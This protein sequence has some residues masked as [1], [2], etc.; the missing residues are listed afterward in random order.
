FAMIFLALAKIGVVTAFINENLRLDALVHS[1][2][3]IQT[4][5]V[6]FDAVFEEAMLEVHEKLNENQKLLLYSYGSVNSKS[7]IAKNICDEMKEQ[8]D[9]CDISKHDGNFFGMYGVGSTLI[10][11]QTLVIRRKF[12]ASNFWEECLK[13]K[14]TL[15][16]YIGEVC[17]YLLD[18]PPKPTDKLHTVRKMY[19]AGLRQTIWRTF[20]E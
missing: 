17:S 8:R 3:C 19:G 7:K 13:Y 18:Q 12:S 16:A 4:K 20:V 10:N 9:D 1:I 11:G 2:T 6:I 5:A 15:A 14:C